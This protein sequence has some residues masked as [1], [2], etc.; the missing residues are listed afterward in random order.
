MEEKNINQETELSSLQTRYKSLQEKFNQQEIVNNDLIHKMLYS[1]ISSF[2]RRNIEIILTYG[3]LSATVCWSWYCFGLRFCFMALSI[4][5]FALIGLIEWGSCRK[6]LEINIEDSDMQTLTRKMENIRTR[7]SVVWIIGVFALCLWVIWFIF[8]LGEKLMMDDLR[9]SF[10]IVAVILIISIILIICNIGRL[11]KK[12]D[13]LLAQTSRLNNGVPAVIPVYHRSGAY[14]SGIAM[15]V[16]S[17]VG[18]VLK[19]MHWPFGNFVF[20]AAGA[21]GLV[22]VWLTCRYLARIVPEDRQVVQVAK[23]GGMFLVLAMVFKLLHWPGGNL[24]LLIVLLLFVVALV[25]KWV[26]YARSTHA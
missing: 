17:L 6:V 8:E 24:L 11:A 9:A 12:S 21:V 22:F 7:F 16:L 23:W 1:E 13:N 26:K 4:L 25:T 15:L 3:L 2:K 10:I 14:W 19:L 5:L 20:M 18:L